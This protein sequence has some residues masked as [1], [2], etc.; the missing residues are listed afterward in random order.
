MDALLA[1]LVNASQ[2]AALGHAKGSDDIGLFDGSLDAELRGE[3]TKGFLISFVM[4]EDS[5]GPAEIDPLSVLPHDAD[6]IVNAGSVFA[7]Q[8]Q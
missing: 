7:H 8:R 5:L 6:Q 2:H 4:L 1:I 3:H